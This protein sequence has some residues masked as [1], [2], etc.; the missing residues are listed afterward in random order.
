MRLA[1]DPGT[2]RIGVARSDPGGVLA[3]PLTVV[4]RGKGDLDALA[5]LA[6]AEEAME[7]LV[8]L[9]RSLSGR[10][11]PAAA[12]ARQF[13]ADLAARVA[14]LPVR[15][16]D[17]RFTTSTAHEALRAGG[18]DSRARRQTVDAAA[19]AVLLEAAL[20]SERRTGAGRPANWCPRRP[21]GPGPR[22][23]RLRRPRRTTHGPGLRRAGLR[24]AGLRRAGLRRARPAP[25]RPASRLCGPGWRLRPRPGPEARV[26]ASSNRA[27][28]RYGSQGYGQDYDP[29][30][31]GQ[32]QA[33]GQG[34]G[35]PQGRDQGYGQQGGQPDP[36]RPGPRQPRGPRRHARRDADAQQAW[37]GGGQQQAYG[38][39]QRGRGPARTRRGSSRAGTTLRDPRGAAPAVRPTAIQV[40]AIRARATR[41]TRTRA[42]ATR[43]AATPGTAGRPGR[44]A[45]LGRRRPRPRLGLPARLRPGEAG[46]YP[47]Y[48]DAGGPSSSRP[49]RPRRRPRPRRRQGRRRLGR[50]R[51]PAGAAAR[52]AAWPRGSRCW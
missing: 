39:G 48:E 22:S 36:G 6:A 33:P 11:G 25:A 37:P 47:G 42:A 1:V 26:P 12:G 45:G 46:G 38:A 51:R 16:V 49:A 30:G 20:E 13:A 23:E 24:R 27:T 31:Y 15:L 14:P 21:A 34:Y 10:E 43:A 28:R 2:V 50:R 17:E 29:R 7:I 8:G 4:R 44:P 32:P 41:V 52:S 19:A 35:S 18:H 9:P 5:S 3:T 40:R